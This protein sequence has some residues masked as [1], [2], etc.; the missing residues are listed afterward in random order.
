VR[1]SSNGNG[2][3]PPAQPVASSESASPAGERRQPEPSSPI[4]TTFGN[5]HCCAEWHLAK[6]YLICALIYPFALRLSRNSGKFVCSAAR[7]AEYFDVSLRTVQRAYRDLR[8]LG[9]F[10]LLESGK[11]KFEPSIFKVM[12]HKEW[13]TRNPGKCVEKIAYQ[14]TAEG[15]PLG[16]SLWV[17]SGCQVLFQPF[18]V[19]AYRDEGIPEP[20]I[21]SLFSAWY[22]VQKAQRWG[23]KW[24]KGVGYHFLMHLRE[25]V[26]RP[27]AAVGPAAPTLRGDAVRPVG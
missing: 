12:N 22:S 13:A 6:L 19:K 26:R 15:D 24:R 10:V 25:H 9:F 23:K 27:N 3:I 17:A 20:E 5:Y 11:D 8:T 4:D 18:Q 16:K 14:W 7:V 21:I 1:N 2:S